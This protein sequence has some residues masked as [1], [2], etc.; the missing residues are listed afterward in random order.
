MSI[1]LR[2]TTSLA[3]HPYTCG[4]LGGNGEFIW[5]GYSIGDLFAL[6]D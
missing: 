4:G 3:S 2:L 5:F 6:G 1:I